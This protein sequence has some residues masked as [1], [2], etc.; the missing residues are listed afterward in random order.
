MRLEEIKNEFPKTPDFIHTMIVQEVDRNLKDN[1]G[2]VKKRLLWDFRRV[3]AILL[4]CVLATSTVAFAA[5]KLYHMR[6]EKQGTYKTETKIEQENTLQIPETIHEIDIQADYIPDG[7]VWT[8]KEL[9]GLKMSNKDHLCHGGFSIRPV[10]MDTLDVEGV[11]Q[12]INVVA[13]E[14]I[15][16]GEHTGVYLKYYDLFEDYSFNQR[17]YLL[18]PELYRVV[19]VYIGDDV[20]KEEAIKF[21]K[22]LKITENSE[23]LKTAE[24]P[25]WSAICK[26][27]EFENAE[28]VEDDKIYVKEDAVHIHEIGESFVVYGKS[29]EGNDGNYIDATNGG[30]TARVDDI[31]LADDLQLI[32]GGRFPKEW[33]NITD[34][35]GKI[36]KNH[37]SY[38]KLGD[39]SSTLDQIVR[40]ED[41][42]QKLLYVTVT[43]TNT[44]DI[45]INHVLYLG[46]LLFLKKQDDT[47][48]QYDRMYEPGDD[49][50]CIHGDSEAHLREMQYASH[51]EDYGNG[52]NYFSLEPGESIEIQMGWIVNE[53][54]LE[55]M[56]LSLS[57]YS[58]CLLNKY[59]LRTG[60]VYVGDRNMK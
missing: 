5:T 9:E 58:G 55:D 13:G 43:Y 24:M 32:N 15:T 14:E 18:Y 45:T 57:G 52:G 12:D 26:E 30:I 41:V 17:I 1:R 29:G 46:N 20:S 49:Y 56:Y 35:N 3:A 37:L 16:L 36:V 33:E 50:D 6:L 23:I 2:S 21:A 53:N 4:A 48:V 38:I 31:K 59:D 51:R 39:G 11:M 34:E 10:L 54:E 47:Y 60:Y 42:N 19:V 7:M 8:L 44:T 28:S 22:N 25:T 27:Q 40:E